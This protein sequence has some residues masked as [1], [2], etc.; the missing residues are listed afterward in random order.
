M[1]L[2]GAFQCDVRGGATHQLDEV[3][4]FLCG[5]AVA[6]DVADDFRIYLCSGVETE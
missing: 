2:E 5:V 1:G 4:V 6:H 3:P